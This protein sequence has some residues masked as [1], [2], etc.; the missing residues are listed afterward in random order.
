LQSADEVGRHSLE[1]FLVRPQLR[2]HRELSQGERR[3]IDERNFSAALRPNWNLK[4]AHHVGV[5]V[6]SNCTET[7]DRHPKAGGIGQYNS[8]P[9][10]FK[11]DPQAARCELDFICAFIMGW[12]SVVFP[13]VPLVNVGV[14]V[15]RVCHFQLDPIVRVTSKAPFSFES[16]KR[17]HQLEGQPVAGKILQNPTTGIRHRNLL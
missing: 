3:G 16:E 4:T 12:S 15:G 17:V 10:K 7:A 11:H 5:K 14:D 6:M 9:T 2:L 1:L 8:I 13:A